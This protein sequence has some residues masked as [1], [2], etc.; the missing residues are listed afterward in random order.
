M[1]IPVFEHMDDLEARS[2]PSIIG[3]LIAGGVVFGVIFLILLIPLLQ[4]GFLSLRA[5]L[6]QWIGRFAGDLLAKF[7]HGDRSAN[8]SRPSPQ[9]DSGWRSP[10]T[11]IRS[12]EPIYTAGPPPPYDPSRLPGYERHD[13]DYRGCERNTSLS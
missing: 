5:I 6:L 9:T 12:P 7:V 10:V 8:A 13:S 11:A 1:L 2:A 4:E 3:I